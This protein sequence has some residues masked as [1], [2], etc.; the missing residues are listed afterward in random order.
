MLPPLPPDP[1]PLP[2]S[3][4]LRI[5]VAQVAR[6]D[7]SAL[8]QL[9]EELSPRVLGIARQILQDGA[10]AED[11]VVEVF[12][13]VWRQADRYDPAKGSVATWIGTLARTR[14]I[15]IRRSLQ[16]HSTRAS[17]LEADDVGK[18]L[19]PGEAPWL[20][21]GDAERASTVRAALDRLPGEQRRALEAAFFG[22]LSHSEIA[23]ALGAPLGTVKTRIRSGLSA[24]RLTLG[25]IEGKMA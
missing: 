18:L 19:D 22:G 7:E 10:A 20:A 5:H 14:S 23:A 3:D 15:D 4:E 16:R 11:V 8:R 13:Q 24:L 1:A 17:S 2:G 21:A 9:Y 6:G 25:S 12:A